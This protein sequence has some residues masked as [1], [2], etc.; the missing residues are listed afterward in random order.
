VQSKKENKRKQKGRIC[1][2]CADRNGKGS[3]GPIKRKKKEEERPPQS[4]AG[5]KNTSDEPNKREKHQ[6]GLGGH[7]PRGPVTYTVKY[8]SAAK[9]PEVKGQANISPIMCLSRKATQD[10]MRGAS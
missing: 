8:K 4:R 2:G 3:P 1:V 5:G 10:Q 6:V 9:K 7:D